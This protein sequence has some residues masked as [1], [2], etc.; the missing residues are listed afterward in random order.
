MN[1]PLNI[2]SILDGKTKKRNCVVCETD[3]TYEKYRL[4]YSN[5]LYKTSEDNSRYLIFIRHFPG[6]CNFK[7]EAVYLL[8]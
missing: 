6:L 8:H 4:T 1:S 2:S 7:N 3:S 5:F